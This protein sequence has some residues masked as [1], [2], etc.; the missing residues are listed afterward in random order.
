MRCF[1]F[2]CVQSPSVNRSPR[3]QIRNDVAL[4]KLASTG[5]G[6][7][8]HLNVDGQSDHLAYNIHLRPVTSTTARLPTTTDLV[9]HAP[10]IT[11]RSEK[12]ETSP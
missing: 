10:S 11:I 9:D 6:D 5:V 8:T 1:S 2:V 7:Q 4:G 3:P 12:I